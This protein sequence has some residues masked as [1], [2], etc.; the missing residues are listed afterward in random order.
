RPWTFAPVN[1]LAA[2]LRDVLASA[3]PP[4]TSLIACP[5]NSARLC[6]REEV[7]MTFAALAF[8]CSTDLKDLVFWLW[9]VARLE[10]PPPAVAAPGRA[11]AV[12]PALA[13]PLSGE[14][15]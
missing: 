5:L 15:R 13:C 2:A 11:A 14:V 12:V 1:N 4:A 9:A 6:S 7:C 3:G 10:Q 8:S